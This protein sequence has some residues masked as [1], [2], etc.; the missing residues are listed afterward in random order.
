MTSGAKIVGLRNKNAMTQSDLAEKLEIP[1]KTLSLWETNII[2]PN[3]SQREQLAEI[4][5]VDPQELISDDDGEPIFRDH[6]EDKSPVNVALCKKY[7][8]CF[9][10]VAMALS[11]CTPILGPFVFIPSLISAW[12]TQHY[13]R[14][15]LP[16][17]NIWLSF[18]IFAFVLLGVFLSILL[19]M[20]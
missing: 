8:L 16:D 10:A 13:L 5:S 20:L 11:F 7:A 9:F 2:D 14:K 6:P 19:F 3:K 15:A 4:F 1:L 18:G 17:S 12:F